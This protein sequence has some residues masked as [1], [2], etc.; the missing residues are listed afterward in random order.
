MDFRSHV[1]QSLR[2]TMDEKGYWILNLYAID[3][4]TMWADVEIDVTDRQG[5]LDEGRART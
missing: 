1:S 3:G 4:L 5:S 2:K